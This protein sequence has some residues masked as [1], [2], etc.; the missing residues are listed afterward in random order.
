MSS[1]N[2][3]YWLC[4][5]DCRFVDE[6]YQSDIVTEVYNKI[7]CLHDVTLAPLLFAPLQGKAL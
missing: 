2:M 6:L 4:V 3:I 1:L 7:S 5:L